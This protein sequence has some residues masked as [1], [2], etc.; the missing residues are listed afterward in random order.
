MGARVDRP[1]IIAMNKLGEVIDDIEKEQGR[2]AL[3]RI[4]TYVMENAG[5]EI[6]ETPAEPLVLERERDAPPQDE[7]DA[8]PA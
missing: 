8:A 5:F 3:A 2:P 6:R 1:D 4:L 7:G